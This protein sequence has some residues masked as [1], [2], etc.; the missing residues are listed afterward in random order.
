MYYINQFLTNLINQGSHFNFLTGPQI[1]S[2]MKVFF[3]F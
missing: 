3:Q 1:V 2:Q